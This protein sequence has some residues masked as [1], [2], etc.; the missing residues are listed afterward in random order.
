[1]KIGEHIR[2]YYAGRVAR[3]TLLT[4]ILP[5]VFVSY[6]VTL[7]LAILLSPGLHDWY[8][9]TISQLAFHPKGHGGTTTAGSPR[10]DLR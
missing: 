4:A 10:A 6:F 9:T 7:I 8:S 3:R 2:G 1:M 5:A